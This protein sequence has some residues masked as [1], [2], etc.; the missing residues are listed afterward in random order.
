MS[1]AKSKKEEALQ[2]LDDLDFNVDDVPS[3]S[4]LPTEGDQSPRPAT[5]TSG[6][7]SS[8]DQHHQDDQ[9]IQGEQTIGDKEADEALNFL[10]GLTLKRSSSTIPRSSSVP[11][12]VGSPVAV[13]SAIPVTTSVSSPSPASAPV[14]IQSTNVD[15]SSGQP[16]VPTSTSTQASTSSSSWGWSAPSLWGSASAAIQQ[17]RTTA[18]S[19]Q[20]EGTKAVQSAMGDVVQ[21]VGVGDAKARAGQAVEEGRKWGGSLLSG[22]VKGVGQVD[23]EKLRH[24]L[25]VA[26]QSGFSTLLATIAPPISEHEVIEIWLSHEMFG[27][28]GVEGVVYRSLSKILEQV[29]GGELIVNRGKT[30]PVPRSNSGKERDLNAIQGMAVASKVAEAGLK[31]LIDGHVSKPNQP[32]AIGLPVTVSPVFLRIQPVLAPLPYAEPSIIS[33]SPSPSGPSAEGE[34]PPAVTPISTPNPDHLSFIVLLSD[35][36]HGL[37]SSTVSQAV[38]GGWLNVGYDEGEWVEEHL[39]GVLG[40]AVEIV[41]QDYVARRMGILETTTGSAEVRDD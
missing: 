24:D 2:F 33:L 28:D 18:E 20:R 38:P 16:N 7:V 34:V 35:Q 37:R 9:S 40:K 32:T 27:Y 5:E 39:V 22:L 14:P 10:N 11:P 4:D 26:S 21:E 31:E 8:L 23:L 19:L 17:A 12:A 25:V 41:G 30:D 15:S 36:A 1:K 29:E 6:T 13:P 3:S